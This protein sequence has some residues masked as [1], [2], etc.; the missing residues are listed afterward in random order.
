MKAFNIPAVGFSVVCAAL[1]WGAAPAQ[2]DGLVARGAIHQTA[3]GGLA[4][5]SAVASD[6]PLGAAT[7]Q[8]RVFGDGQGN[9]VGASS[10]AFTTDAGGHGAR[11]A[12]Y[13]RNAD[14]SASASAN[15]SANGQ[16]GSAERNAS[17]TRNADGS[18]SGSRNT[19][20]TNANTGVTYDGAT[21]YS[22]GSGLSRSASCTDAAGNSVSCGRR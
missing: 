3:Q 2:A 15:A 7:G 19:T 18:A 5:R 14:G 22:K 4:A 6:G 12:R 16:N 9:V 20:V 1:T 10:S 11:S 21:T 13:D 8:R 17:W